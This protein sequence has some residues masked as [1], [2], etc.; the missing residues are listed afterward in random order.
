MAY[1][2]IIVDD[3]PIFRDGFKSFLSIQESVK[4][5]LEAENGKIFLDVLQ[6]SKVDLAFVDI[7][8]PEKD[9]FD[10]TREALEIQ[11]DLKIIGISSFENIEYIDKMLDCGASG[12]L[13]KDAERKEISEAIERVMKGGNYFS[14]RVL[15]KLTQRVIVKQKEKRER[16]SLPNFTDREKEILQQYCNGLSRSEIAEQLF[17]SER[18]VDKHRENLQL[19][20]GVKNT[21]GLVLYSIKYKIAKPGL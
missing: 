12:Y 4:E 10:A 7:N 15:T 2:V 18:T 11:P 13:L 1:R 9:G 6:T 20:T 14:S 19:K 8:M 16:I 17:I 3:H 21:V 5:V